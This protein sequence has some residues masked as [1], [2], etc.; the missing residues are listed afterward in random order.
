MEKKKWLCL[1]DLSGLGSR[2]K[3]GHLPDHE[4][5]S[6]REKVAKNFQGKIKQSAE[7]NH[8]LFWKKKRA[9]V[10]K[11]VPRIAP[12]ER[13]HPGQETSL[14]YLVLMRPCCREGQGGVRKKGFCNKEDR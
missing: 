7:K 6:R 1:S 3:N 4:F 8:R 9:R 13:R 10:Q 14:R 5:P 12:G 11:K 2:K